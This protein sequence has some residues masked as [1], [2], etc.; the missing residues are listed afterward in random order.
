MSKV[1]VPYIVGNR[2]ETL[3]KK[4]VYKEYLVHGTDFFVEELNRLYKG[5]I[6]ELTEKVADNI[7]DTPVRV[8]RVYPHGTYYRKSGVYQID[9]VLKELESEK[10]RI[11]SFNAIKGANIVI[12]MT[13]VSEYPVLY[14]QPQMSIH[15]K[16]AFERLNEFLRHD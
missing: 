8:E 2:L 13:F 7:T 12:N 4:K 5:R 11:V 3:K 16:H 10:E 6:G 9:L 14:L 1:F 15:Q